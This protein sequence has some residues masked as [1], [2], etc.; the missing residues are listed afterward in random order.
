MLM[1]T[2]TSLLLSG[3][4]VRHYHPYTGVDLVVE[5]TKDH[6]RGGNSGGGD[7]PARDWEDQLAGRDPSSQVHF[8]ESCFW[9]LAKGAAGGWGTLIFLPAWK[10]GWS[11][12][13]V[14]GLEATL[15]PL[16]PVS[17]PSFPSARSLAT[18]F[19]FILIQRQVK[20]E[21]KAIFASAPQVKNSEGPK[22]PTE[23][24]ALGPRNTGK[25]SREHSEVRSCG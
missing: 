23:A 16:P 25:C 6:W 20:G 24:S 18:C 2:G 3:Y 8:L 9:D 11:G 22:A 21:R 17:S 4:P 19:N 1:E 7:T 5:T 15:F 10:E 13:A 14:P 12:P